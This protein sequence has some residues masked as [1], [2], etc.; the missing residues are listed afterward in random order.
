[1][2]SSE[3]EIEFILHRPFVKEGDYKVQQNGQIALIKVSRIQNVESLQKIFVGMEIIGTLEISHDYHGIGNIWK[4][5]MTIPYVPK[6]D[7][8]RQ[9]VQQCLRYLNRGCTV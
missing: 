6:A 9:F 4:I 2:S 7:A 5:T 3:T 1:M 8:S